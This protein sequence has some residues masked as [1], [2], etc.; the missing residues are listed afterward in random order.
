ML[1]AL[2]GY[3]IFNSFAQ[4][5]DGN[6]RDLQGIVFPSW[7]VEKLLIFQ[8][9]WEVTLSDWGTGYFHLW[10]ANFFCT[11]SDTESHRTVSWS[12]VLIFYHFSW[13]LPCV[14]GM[15]WSR[16]GETGNGICW[17]MEHFFLCEFTWSYQS[18][19]L[20]ILHGFQG[21]SLT[22]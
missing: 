22:S 20:M 11:V 10:Q 2:S 7:G 13:A 3:C 18:C 4:K 19:I 15:G 9:A 6:C 16:S 8:G 1:L 5:W 21:F 17:K 12:M 14:Y